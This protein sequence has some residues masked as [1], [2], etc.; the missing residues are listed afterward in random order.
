MRLR[1]HSAIDDE[2]FHDECGVFGVFGHPEAANMTYL[3]LHGLQHRGQ[4]SAGIA[5]ADGKRIHTHRVLGLVQDNFSAETIAA[6]PGDR[7]IGHVRYS[8]AGGSGLSCA[9][10]ITVRSARGWL[11]LAHNG[12]LPDAEDIRLRLEEEGS[13]FQTT[14]DSEVIVHLIARSQGESLTDRIIDA[15][16]Q[17]EGAYS[18]L[19][20]AMDQLVAVRDPY[21]FRPL[22]L[23]RLGNARVVASESTA[24]DLIEAT[25]ERDVA[26]GEMVVIDARGVRSFFPFPP[27]PRRMCIFEHIY[28]ARPD[29]VIDGLPV[30][31]VRR[32]LGERLADE[33]PADADVVIAVPDSGTPAALGYANRLHIPFALGLIRSHYVGR[34]FIEPRQSIRHFGV[35]L[36]LN[37][38]RAVLRGRRV[39]VIDDS[40]VRGTTS[41]KIVRML[42][43]AGAAAVHLRIS[44]PPP[45][46]P[47]DYGI[48]TP[49]REEL[50]ASQQSI[51]AVRDFVRCDTLGYLS[52]E[53]AHAAA[54]GTLSDKQFCDACFSGDYPVAVRRT[55]RSDPPACGC[56]D[57]NGGRDAPDERNQEARR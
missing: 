25:F 16:S 51:E 19:F 41:M 35:K 26:P 24:F 22:C 4:E 46:G 7:A 20:L 34:T 32:R 12:N 1:R 56:G 50:I 5:A 52:L 30:I 31:D 44:S 29:S 11:S 9:Q 55:S 15:L 37:P 33:Q 47:G 6:L 49:T 10:P 28:F 18:L 57:M 39:A 14:T 23:G 2:R 53:G 36:K 45:P 17:V 21:G 8:T 54:G 27:R 43:D 13:I 38:V 40:I 3:G 42:R 48:D